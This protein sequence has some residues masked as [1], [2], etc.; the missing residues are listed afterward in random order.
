MELTASFSA[1]KPTEALTEQNAALRECLGYF[2]MTVN[3]KAFEFLVKAFRKRDQHFF[4]APQR[5]AVL[6]HGQSGGVVGLPK[7]LIVKVC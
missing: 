3:R 4:P 6:L 5:G 7:K 1:V 2:A